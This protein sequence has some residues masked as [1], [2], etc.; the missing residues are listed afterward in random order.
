[1]FTKTAS[2]EVGA[3]PMHGIRVS[4]IWNATVPCMGHGFITYGVS[5]KYAS[6]GHSSPPLLSVGSMKPCRFLHE[7]YTFLGYYH[8]NCHPC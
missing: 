3:C 5:G 4:H 7:T 8:P 1:M 2:P 6:C